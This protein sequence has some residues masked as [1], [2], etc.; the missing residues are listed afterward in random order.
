M[1]SK[2]LSFVA[3]AFSALL[4]LTLSV[5]ALASDG[6]LSLNV[7]PV[8]ILVNGQVFQPKDAKG[9]DAMTFTCNGTTYAPLR[10]LAEAYGLQVGYDSAKQIVTVDTQS[11]QTSTET[12]STDYTDAARADFENQWTITEKPVTNYG[13]EKIFTAVYSGSMSMS[14]FK[15][16]WKS[17][18]DDEISRGAE[19]LAAEAQRL[20]PGY[21]VTMYFSYGSYKLGTAFAYGDYELSNFDLAS[22]WIK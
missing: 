13:S 10:A 11:A 17:F 12:V 2:F 19:S 20:V 6:S 15:S 21:T 4:I 3:G 1:K 8:K 5:S 16:W 9:N 7:Q 18:S 14:A 22:V